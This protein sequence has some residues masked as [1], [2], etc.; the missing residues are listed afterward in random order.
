MA[1]EAVK[2]RE[3]KRQKLVAL[4]AERRAALK[5]AGD[6]E[7]LD[8]LPRNSSKVSST[9]KDWK[10]RLP[11][12]IDGLLVSAIKGKGGMPPKGTCRSCSDE[13]L[14]LSI[15]YMLPTFPR[16]PRHGQQF[17]SQGC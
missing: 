3:I 14:R 11:M 1:R 8:K 13:E 17:Q 6:Y 12:G 15:E 10:E 4:Y 5:E 9:L 2:A 16:S 7:G